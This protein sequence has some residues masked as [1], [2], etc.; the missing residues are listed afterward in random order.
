MPLTPTRTRRLSR[1]ARTPRRLSPGAGPAAP[2]DAAIRPRD[3][4]HLAA[5]VQTSLSRLIGRRVC[6]DA[7]GNLTLPHRRHTSWIVVAESGQR[8]SFCWRC[9]SVLDDTA[10]ARLAVATES[11]W[12]DIHLTRV[13]P[14]VQ[15]TLRLPTPVFV[16]ENLRHASHLWGAFLTS[17]ADEV[18]QICSG[19][20]SLDR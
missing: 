13:G 18:M 14:D 1:T 4:R 6:T 16:A 17:G 10:F 19:R 20:R 7:L 9:P 11:R 12:P 8:V 5:L 2:T 3:Q 15:A